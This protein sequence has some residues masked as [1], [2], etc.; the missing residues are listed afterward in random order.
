MQFH[1]S[2]AGVSTSQ[3]DVLTNDSDVEWICKICKKGGNM[4]NKTITWGDYNTE[5]EVRVEIEKIYLELVSW[6]NNL[7]P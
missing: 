5:Q 3:F 1:I 2:C 4:D 6:T 7:M